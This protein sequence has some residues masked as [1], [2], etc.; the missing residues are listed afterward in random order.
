MGTWTEVRE[1]KR[2]L[3]VEGKLAKGVAKAA[4]VLDL[5]SGGRLPDG[6]KIIVR[7]KSK[8]GRPTLEFQIGDRYIKVRYD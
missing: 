8:E 2:G 4:K 6:S 1:D 7:L 5:I 3:Y